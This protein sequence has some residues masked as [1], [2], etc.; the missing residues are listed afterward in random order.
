MV[1]PEIPVLV[2]YPVFK[3][4]E[5]LIF[6]VAPHLHCARSQWRVHERALAARMGYYIVHLIA[7]PFEVGKAFVQLLIGGQF[8]RPP[9]DALAAECLIY[10]RCAAESENGV[11]LQLEHLPAHKMNYV[12]LYDMHL[13]AVPH[14]DGVGIELPKIFVVAVD[15]QHGERKI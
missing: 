4:G 8:L 9:G 6:G 5:H 10:A 12:Q 15:E 1:V 14:C 7:I 11:A 13:A 3:V 2:S